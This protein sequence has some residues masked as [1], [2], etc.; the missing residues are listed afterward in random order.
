MLVQPRLE[1][2]AHDGTISYVDAILR[3]RVRTIDTNAK[4]RP[5]AAPAPPNINELVAELFDPVLETLLDVGNGSHRLS[6]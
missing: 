2:S 3:R 5:L 4:N 6:L 1:R